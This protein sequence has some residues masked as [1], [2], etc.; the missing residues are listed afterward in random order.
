MGMKGFT[1]SQH[2]KTKRIPRGWARRRSSP[3]P[4]R[5]RALVESSIALA[6]QKDVQTLSEVLPS[7]AVRRLQAEMSD[8]CTRSKGQGLIAL[9]LERYCVLRGQ[10]LRDLPSNHP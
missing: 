7:N 9:H 1:G 3:A 4:A 8:I 6:L 10:L 5:R 2:V